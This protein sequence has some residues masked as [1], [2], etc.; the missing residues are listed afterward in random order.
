MQ[1]NIKKK[2]IILLK[3]KNILID[4]YNRKSVKLSKIRSIVGDRYKIDLSF[5][6]E[7]VKSL[8]LLN[9]FSKKI[10]PISYST[11]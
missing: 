10:V 5:D 4:L 7:D 1:R 6:K 2:A 11:I 8:I 3:N 9:K